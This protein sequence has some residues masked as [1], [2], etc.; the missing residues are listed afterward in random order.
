MSAA[1]AGRLRFGYGTNGL[2]DHALPDALAWLAEVGYAGVAVTLDHRLEPFAPGLAARAGALGEQARRLGLGLVVETGARYVLDRAAKH[3]PTLCSEDPDGRRRRLDYLR[4]AIDAGAG[5]GAE[6][7][8]FWSGTPDAGTPP[9]A[10]WDRLRAGC[11]ELVDH[12]AGRGVTLGFEPE[13]G[14]LVDRLSGY[15]R[16]AADLGDPAG[17]GLTLDVG[18]C[19]S[20]ED[21]D[22]PACVRRAAPRLVNVQIDDMRRGEH[23]HLDFGEG[24]IDFPPVLAAFAEAGYRGLVAVELPRH[25]HQAHRTV[26]A[27]LAFL[28]AAERRPEHMVR[29]P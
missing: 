5:M 10:A 1:P 6:A 14:M 7:V 21:D 4:L 9:T 8:S 11:A 27:S 2:A 3:Q 17:F 12:A 20:N 18:H 29:I 28:R 24:E 13:P 22:V 16:L 26:P 23:E 19:R 25:S 15:E